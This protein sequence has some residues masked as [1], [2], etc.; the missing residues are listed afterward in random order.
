MRR[1]K[2]KKLILRQLGRRVGWSACVMCCQRR[3]TK[4]SHLQ[5]SAE[6]KLDAELLESVFQCL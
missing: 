6:Q 1:K 5:A 2:L 3:W 4:C